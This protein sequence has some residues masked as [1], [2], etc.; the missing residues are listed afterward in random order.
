MSL[1][2]LFPIE[3]AD[4]R[5]NMREIGQHDRLLKI[6]PDQLAAVTRAMRANRSD[7]L[8]FR[9][10][11]DHFV[12]SGR[13]LDV[14]GLEKGDAITLGDFDGEVL[15]VDNPLNGPRD[16]LKLAN[17][18]ATA[19]MAGVGLGILAVMLVGGAALLPALGMAALGVAASGALAWPYFYGASALYRKVSSAPGTDTLAPFEN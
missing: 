8:V 15:A 7:D 6:K 18:G 13:N 16:S 3:R 17:L 10:G 4:R 14:D 12:A 19:V 2:T 11:K 1:S 9:V 5:G